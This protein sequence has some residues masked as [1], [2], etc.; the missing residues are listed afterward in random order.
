MQ[1]P[2]HAT[3]DNG[4]EP[5]RHASDVFEKRLL[6]EETE[7]PP[8]LERDSSLPDRFD[9]LPIELAS[10][11]DRFVESLT[12]KTFPEPPS[13]DAISE[14]F[15]EFYSKASSHINTHISALSSKLNREASPSAS[16]SRSS[17]S[18]KSAV[19]RTK[20]SRDS[21]RSLHKDP[22]DQQMLTASEV[23]ERRKARRMLEVKRAILEEAVERRAC[24][25][26]YD[27]IWRHKATLDE[28]RDEKLRSKQAALSLVGIGL[29]DL[30]IEVGEQA[31]DGENTVREWLVPARTSLAQMDDEKYP[32]GKL[33]HLQTAHKT[34]VETLS[35]FHP[36]S[37]SA[38]EILPTLIFTLITSPPEGINII[39]NLYFI[40]RFRAATRIDGEAAYCMTNLEAAISF[41]ENVDLSSLRADEFPEGPGKPSSRPPTPLSSNKSEPF[42][43]LSPAMPPLSGEPTTSIT[44]STASA[45]LKPE[46]AN[47][48][49][50][51][52]RRVSNPFQLPSKVI[53]AANDAVRNTAEEVSKNIT[54]SLDN[55]FKF[56]FGRLKEHTQENSNVDVVLPKTL[57]EARLL[58]NPYPP[59]DGSISEVSSITDLPLESPEVRNSTKSDDKLLGMIGG[60]KPSLVRDRSVDSTQSGGSSRKVGFAPT[61]TP[62]NPSQTPTSTSTA[63]PNPFDSV[64]NLGNSL[65]PLNHL[66]AFGGGLRGFGSKPA[67]ASTTN[68]I[69]ENEKP[70]TPLTSTGSLEIPKEVKETIKFDPPI[71]KFLVTQDAADLKVGDVADLLRDYQRLAAVLAQI[72]RSET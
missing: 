3:A 11:T 16:S 12:S 18:S 1:T 62:S 49:P 60:L 54:N 56:L 68:T 19:P 13:I 14:L 27:K 63:T 42:P 37:S 35:K 55:S 39:S 59:E 64:K 67:P 7:P 5:K 26:V 28:V 53:G 23:T 41:V 43:A 25:K 36:S 50:P 31:A 2:A 72:K 22:S 65:N 29:K 71:R 40:E 32:L 44:D 24:E 21:L 9:E 58:V 33:R 51:R 38:D 69:Q 47:E 66:G 30:G 34:I 17:I 4:H 20:A 70:R 61:N 57:D 48:Q 46:T 15:Q 6:L 45:T 10:L 52:P 8:E